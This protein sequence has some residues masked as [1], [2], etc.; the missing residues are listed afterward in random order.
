MAYRSD[1]LSDLT[2]AD[3]DELQRRG[4]RLVCDF[5]YE[6]EIAVDPSR[7]PPG[8]E[9]RRVP[10]GADL[11]DSDRTVEE[12]IRLGELRSITTEEVAV[13]YLLMLEAR[14]ELFGEVVRLVA[15]TERRRER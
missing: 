15:D 1:K 6:R 12:R 11:S 2:D 14:A 4:V 9:G 7:L 5:R 8:A 13:G 10:V 3:L